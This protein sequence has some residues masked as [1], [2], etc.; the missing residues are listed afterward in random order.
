GTD[1]PPG[2]RRDDVGD[3]AG[4]RAAQGPALRHR[5]T[6]HATSSHRLDDAAV[7]LLQLRGL[8]APALLLLG[9]PLV[10]LPRRPGTRVFG[11]LQADLDHVWQRIEV[12]LPLAGLVA[13]A[14]QLPQVALHVSEIGR[15]HV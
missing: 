10:P 7:S 14:T 8:T 13:N 5:P 15:A 3:A 9:P 12:D 6:E 4:Q 2:V 1:D 11:Q